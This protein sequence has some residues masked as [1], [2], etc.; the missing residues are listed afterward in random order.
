MDGIIYLI[1]IFEKLYGSSVIAFFVFAGL[2]LLKDGFAAL[3]R[4]SAGTVN[5]VTHNLLLNLFNAAVGA[6]VFG[7]LNFLS[8]LFF[9]Q[10]SLPH[11]SKDLWVNIPSAFIFI[12]ALFALDFQNYWSHRL[13][14]TK[15]FW[16]V[17]ALHH[18]DAHMTWTTSYRIH[19]F[20]WVLMS[21]VYVAFV[22]WLFIPTE[23]VVMV[24]IIRVW[25]GKFNHAQLGWTFGKFRKILASPNYHRWHHS[26]SKEAYDKNLA[27]MF[28]IWDIMFGTHYDP[29]LCET[30]IGVE[31]IKDGF[32][33][34]QL[35]PFKYAF[36]AI[37]RRL[38]K[39]QALPSD[40]NIP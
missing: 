5:E 36:D 29:G 13:L 25:Y 28:P 24:A 9:E 30:E 40:G 6:V 10:L 18:S 16:G 26:V 3:K 15:Y 2:F 4:P 23:I 33:P 7:N 11:L 31:D 14:H 27:D 12:F 1:N 22:G 17:H 32:I 19:V 21:I 39:G 38:P 35:Y 8:H 37:K 34:G 20:E